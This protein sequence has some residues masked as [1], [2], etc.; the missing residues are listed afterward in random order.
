MDAVRKRLT[1]QKH[2][3]V[4]VA[5]GVVL[6]LL[7]VFGFRTTFSGGEELLVGVPAVVLGAALGYVLAK[8]RAPLLVGV[9][10][11]AVVFFVLAGPVALRHRAIAGFLPGPEAVSAVASGLVNSWIR[12][13][14]TLPPAGEA[15]DLLT[16]PY[17]CGF[18]GG[19]LT[20]VL[21]LRLRRVPLCVVPPTALLVIGVLFGTRRPASLLLQ[22]AVFGALTI[23]WV[24]V[25][26]RRAR[27]ITTTAMPRQRVAL[28]VGLV[29][30][31]GL[32]GI[33][34]GPRL[35][36]AGAND[37]F[38][39]RDEVE[40]PFDP[41][42]EPSALAAYRNY[43]DEDVR[44]DDVVT[45][46]GLPQDARLRISVMDDYDDLVW[47]ATG[48][49]SV[50]SGEYL[51]VGARIPSDGLGDE[52]RVDVE[53]H[54]PHGVW[55]PLAGDVTSL[56]FE[57]DDAERLTDEVRVSPETDTAA[58]PGELE[59]GDRYSFTAEFAP[60]PSI[61]ELSKM[62]LDGRF[63]RETDAAVPTEFVTQASEWAGAASSPHAELS[64][65]ASVLRTDGRFS[66]G[67]P[68]ANPKSAPGHS[69]LRLLQFLDNDNPFGNGEQFGAALG[70]LA[71]A[72]GI[73]VRVVMGFVNEDGGDVV[74]FTGEDIDA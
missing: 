19:V 47:R 4:D 44:E 39:L 57:G 33:V 72:R 27:E 74:T 55:V 13:L 1:P 35:P 25:R 34:V 48:S 36:G 9:A 30:I 40:P 12:L 71:K 67:G 54:K 68:E 28:A 37:R 73:P 18:A 11:S 52:R 46:R 69:L 17:F 26:H 32:G 60:L 51:R 50:L 43:S 10:V 8:L 65:I 41:L 15:G 29:M 6:A 64:A 66:D 23:A 14:T 56:D 5:F 2:E 3:L 31:A 49:G 38:V 7:G 16:V 59:A 22:G 53:I 70:L 24:S 42:S 58:V 61:E 21:A 45:V 62:P 20:V 63:R